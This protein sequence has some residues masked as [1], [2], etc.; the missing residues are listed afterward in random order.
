M[1]DVMVSEEY[2]SRN[3]QSGFIMDGIHWH[4][5]NGELETHFRNIREHHRRRFVCVHLRQYDD[6]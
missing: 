3:N 2:A 5:R 6:A 4:A 1:I